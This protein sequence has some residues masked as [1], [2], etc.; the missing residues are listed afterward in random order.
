[1]R[2]AYAAIAAAPLALGAVTLPH[3]FTNGT[4]ADAD[5][6]NANFAALRDA[7]EAQESRLSA[8]RW[9]VDASLHST[10]G[11][12]GFT[13][14]LF[15]VPVLEP[16]SGSQVTLT[17]AGSVD[18]LLACE[19]SDVPTSGSCG[20]TDGDDGSSAGIQFVPPTPGPVEVCATFTHSLRTSTTGYAFFTLVLTE[21]DD[22]TA[23]LA[24]GSTVVTSGGSS[25]SRPAL[26]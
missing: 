9:W 20:D 10:L 23:V 15:T 17:N 16:V 18:A 4:P 25:S 24:R 7:I 6:V 2:L 14:D 22:D 12:S 13:L 8:G 11:I 26:M 3:T 21:S 19:G 5:E 1:M